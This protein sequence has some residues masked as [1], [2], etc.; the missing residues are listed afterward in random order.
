MKKMKRSFSAAFVVIFLIM[1]STLSTKSFSQQVTGLSGWNIY[2]DPGHSRKE[3]MG[4]YNYSEA[5]KNLSVALNLRQMLLDWTDIDTVYICRTDDIA[6]VSLS[7]RTDQANALGAAHYH[8][9]HSNATSAPTT[10]SNSTLLL[11]GQLGIGGPEKTPNGGKKMSDIMVNLLTAGMRTNTI[12]SIGDRTFYGSPGTVPYL[13]VNRES[14]MASELS[15]A[16]FH[17]NLMQNQLNMNAEWKRLEAKTFFWSILK[18]HNIARPFVGTV[19][20]IIKDLESGLAVNGAV[21]SLNGQSYTTNTWQSLFNQYSSDPELLRNGFYYFEDV[22]SGSFPMQITAPGYDPQEINVTILDTFFTFKDVNLISSVPPTITSTYPN[23]NDSI[24]LG[25]E[26]IKIVFSRSMNKTSV[27]TNFNIIPPANVNFSWSTDNK[28]LNIS[29]SN[30]EFDTNYEITILGNAQDKYAHL[31]D[32]D[33]NGIG[34]DSFSFSFKTKV[35]DVTAPTAAQVHPLAGSTNVELKPVINI[36]FNE[37][38]KTSTISSRF[39]IIRNSNQSSVGGTLRHYI[40]NGRS[41]LNAFFTNVLLENETYSIILMAGI[42]DLAGNPTVQDLTFQFTTG[43]SNYVSQIS[44]DNFDNGIDAWWQPTASGSTI[45]VIPDS[46]KISSVNSVI[47]LNTGSV[48]SMMLEYK[49]NLNESNWLIRE[50]RSVA[51]AAFNANTILQAYVFGDGTFNKLRFAIKETVINS[52][53][54]SQW[55]DIDWIGWKLVSWNL[56]EGQ[57]GTWL[58]NGILEP[59]FIYDSFQFTHN[60]GNKHF[61]TLYI[62]D[63]RTAVFQPTDVKIEGENKPTNYILEQN[64][65]N[66]FNPTTKIRY[67]IPPNVKDEKSHTS[68]KIYDVLGHNVATLIDEYKS[69]GTYEVEFSVG[70][71]ISLSSGVYYY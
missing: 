13:H 71:T 64:Y 49:Y 40:V 55:I 60:P 2:L 58:G 62:D 6:Q 31:L 3:N 68:L 11:W 50:F 59:P 39:R 66:P 70:Q 32:G 19:A 25:V 67:S 5:E 28:T 48:K 22:P 20:G 42:E 65:P 10:T 35:K 41:V 9:I 21:V 16:G 57:T 63:L 30:F 27:E 34:G 8:S 4:V 44:I 14:N 23:V 18:Y 33:K 45:G 51:S 12:G 26:S 43:S 7:Q 37:P 54:V 46:T 29:T 52:Y 1:F 36:S 53:E 24:Y 15:E 38:L 56:M 61:G 17:T 69:A 47:N